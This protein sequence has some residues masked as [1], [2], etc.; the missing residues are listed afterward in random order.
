MLT[1]KVKP[2]DQVT[3][4]LNLYNYVNA[5][6]GR[7]RLDTSKKC[8]NVAKCCKDPQYIANMNDLLLFGGKV[9]SIVYTSIKHRYNRD[10]RHIGDYYYII[11]MDRAGNECEFPIEFIDRSHCLRRNHKRISMYNKIL[12]CEND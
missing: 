9:V 8:L 3:L 6:Q 7:K 5:I 11:V 1:L 10:D 4:K 2:N 12:I